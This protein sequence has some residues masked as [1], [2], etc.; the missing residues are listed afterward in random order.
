M[1]DCARRI[2]ACA[3]IE[4]CAEALDFLRD[5]R[6]IAR[7]RAFREQVRSHVCET[8]KL[9]RIDFTTVF[10]QQLRGNERRLTTLNDD[11]AQTVRKCFFDWFW[12][13]PGARLRRRR[14]RCLRCLCV[15]YNHAAEH[16]NKEKQKSCHHL[17]PPALFFDASG[18]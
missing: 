17:S 13:R 3:R 14:W 6:C 9:W 7:L 5:L 11:H 2:P 18:R 15:D 8:S 10:D 4:R 1:S 12:K 16:N